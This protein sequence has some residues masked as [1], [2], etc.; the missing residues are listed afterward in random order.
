MPS[1]KKVIVSGSDAAL[2]SLNVTT[3][4]TASGIIYP[5]TDGTSGQ[6]VITDGAG[7]LSFS[8]IENTTIIIKNVSGTTIAKGTPC[9]ITGSGTAGNIAGV[10]PADAS[11]PLRMPAGVIA[12]E[13]LISEAEGIGLINGFISG[14]NTSAF[15]PG[16]TI[17]VAAGGGY[18]K[19]R[20]TGS[21]ILIQKL[22]NVEKSSISNGSGVINGP[23]YYNEVPNIQQ[24]FTWVGNSNGVAIPVSTSSLL[25][26]SASFAINASS[27]LF[28][29]SSSRAVSSSFA[30]L[31]ATATSAS[32]A[33]IASSSLFA[34]NASSSLRAISSSFSTL[35]ATATNATNI[36]V[37]DSGD[38][39]TTW[40]LIANNQ[41]GTQEARTDA[42]LIYNAN[43]R[44]LYTTTFSGSLAGT[45]SYATSASQA[46]SSSF[47]INA[48][49]SLFA[50]SS[51]RAVS[52]SFATVAQSVLGTIT[53][54]NTASN[55]TPAITNAANNR[56]LTANGGGTING[57]SNLTFDGTLLYANSSFRQGG[58]SSAAGADSHA[59]GNNTVASADYS[60]AEGDSS[61]AVGEAS[62][63][64]GKGTFAVGNYSHAEGYQTSAS[65]DYSHAEGYNTRATGISSHAE[66]TSSLASGPA[67]HAE[68]RL[69]TA[70][71]L[72]SHAEGESTIAEGIG[73]HTEG[74]LTR[75]SGQASHA[76]GAT[77]NAIGDYS[78]AEGYYAVA[79]GYSSHAEGNATYAGGNASHAAGNYTSASGDYQSVIG[80]WN[81][82]STNP[83]AFIIGNGTGPGD[84]SNLLYASGSNVQITGSFIAS[85]SNNLLNTVQTTDGTKTSPAYS[86]ISDTDT[87]MYR[88]ATNTLA[89]TAGGESR[90]R[91]SDT[92][93]FLVPGSTTLGT[94]L[95]MSDNL[96]YTTRLISTSSITVG[97]ATT[98]ISAS[99]A[100]TALNVINN[101]VTSVATNNGIT[102]GTITST[103]TIGLT[104]QALALHNLST[105]G[106][107]ARTGAGTVAGR[108]LTGTANQITVTNGNGVSGN[109]TIS[110]PA[111]ITGLSSVTS[112][113]FVGAL[114]GNASTATSAT[115]ATTATNATNV[116]VTNTTSGTGP[117]YLMFADGT[118][119]NRATR[120]DSST[121][122]FNATTNTLTVANLTGTSSF[123]T[124]A[125]SATS[126]TSAT[127]AT[128][129]TSASNVTVTTSAGASAFKI[130]FI[131]HTGTTAGTYALLQ[132]SVG[133][134]TYTP[135]TNLL[136]SENIAATNYAFS[137]SIY[138][139]N[140]IGIYD[141]GDLA[142]GDYEAN[143]LNAATS[144]YSNGGLVMS[145]NNQNLYV[146][147]SLGVG[148]SSP[149]TTGLIRATNDI[150]AYY[151]S[152]KRLKDNI[153]PI[154]NALEK[155]LNLGGYEFDWIPMKGIH[156]NEGHDIGVI[157][158][159]VEKIV[160][161]V[162]TTRDN[163][164][165][166]VK[167]E[168]IVP[169]LIESIKEQQKQIDELKEL[170]NKLTK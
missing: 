36:S 68:G 96:N 3:S 123:A 57:E 92:N 69:T 77:T 85:Q 91:L 125:A 16:D 38:D 50:V 35:A 31:A 7:N 61:T 33:T 21:A 144:F 102:G 5:T 105:N 87:G 67:S 169:L 109:P 72:F 49:S 139:Q 17:Y 94:H 153:T 151:S 140:G 170:I 145:V 112:T 62:H 107:I 160:P 134:A 34:T 146:S 32:Y 30:T 141:D 133:G 120:V 25:V 27:S 23:N 84:E 2:N 130:P 42:Q 83:S 148:T 129:A 54:A 104:G 37:S 124:L 65:A 58:A 101:G 12:G 147:H 71:G 82:P 19:I 75:A 55:I 163:G 24:G 165:K 168:K 4:L 20:P 15:N 156:E 118:T 29:V 13:T 135:G 40:V 158:Q 6:V 154:P 22:G 9:Y 117:Y 8:N 88:N 64:E 114:T 95:L 90:I 157:A 103:G 113:A 74:V 93:L 70:S 51:S 155:V 126:A 47:A 86:F 138:T 44:I 66:G 76:E 111:T 110:L 98:A 45:A 127:N 28:A 80:S 53:N 1:W 161:E 14:V 122:T 142:I 48:S 78:H 60:H 26:T 63:A 39:T 73:S 89:L 52:S 119:G 132:D 164:Y 108:T 150:I 46:I 18:T 79:H 100:T 167:Y 149:T 11:N 137:Y 59:E 131:N 162:V 136:S 143:T 56:V 43:S 128:T 116:A 115:S 10:W 41:T 121:L 152:D 99:Y 81:K 97:A 159:E 106:L 166:A